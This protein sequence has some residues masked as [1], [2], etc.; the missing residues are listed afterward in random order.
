MVGVS[1][2]RKWL[3]TADA[4]VVGVDVGGVRKGFHA[5][6]LTDGKYA[7][8]HAT[9]DA[10]EMAAWCR[11]TAKAR[12]VGVDAPCRWSEDGRC[13]AAERELMGQ[14]IW[15]FATPTRKKAVEHPKNYYGWML[16][17]EELFRALEETH[18]L[19]TKLPSR[20]QRCCFETFPHAITW[21]LRCGNADAKKKRQERTELLRDAG[22]NLEAPTNMDFID[23]ALC[24]LMAH[25]AASGDE[26]LCLGESLTGVIIVPSGRRP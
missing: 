23:A 18:P 6:A 13:R 14:G 21:K 8:R 24:A 10:Y 20:G 25:L 26:C 1:H 4:T 5:V 11:D 12:V 22:I 15:C 9:K 16:R 7:G 2:E 19:C 3:T 17:G